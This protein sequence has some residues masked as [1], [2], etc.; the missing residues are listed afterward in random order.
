DSLRRQRLDLL[1][2]RRRTDDHARRNDIDDARRQNAARYMV[3]LVRFVPDD[4][5]MPRVRP[6]LIANYDLE[7][8][9]QQI[10]QLSLGFVP[11]LQ[12]NDASSRHENTF[13][14]IKK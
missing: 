2:D 3:Q 5:R 13:V 1:E 9:G 6:A 7:P 12:T 14:S 11:P 8:R 4:D 10:D